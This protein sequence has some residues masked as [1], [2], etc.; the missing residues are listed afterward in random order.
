MHF[1]IFCC[2]VLAYQFARKLGSTTPL[3]EWDMGL[4]NKLLP[5]CEKYGNFT[6]AYI[7]CFLRH[8]TVPGN[9]PVGTCKLGAGG[10]PTAVVDPNLR[11]V[12]D[13]AGI[14]EY[15]STECTLVVIS[16]VVDKGI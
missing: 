12:V 14:W 16:V 1:T 11:Y 15:N 7:E 8:I 6:N 13:V 2:N 9:A 10:D 5:Q 4:T 3:Q